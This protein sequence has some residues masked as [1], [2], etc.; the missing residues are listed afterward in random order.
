MKN[1][2]LISF[3]IVLLA[4]L[5]AFAQYGNQGSSSQQTSANRASVN[6]GRHAFRQGR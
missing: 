5:S 4:S 3:A 1:L 2:A 6:E